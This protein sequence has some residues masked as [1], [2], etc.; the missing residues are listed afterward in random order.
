MK[1]EEILNRMSLF[2]LSFNQTPREGD[3]FEE[4]IQK[5]NLLEQEK[6]GMSPKQHSYYY[7]LMYKNH[8]APLTD[9]CKLKIEAKIRETPT[10]VLEESDDLVVFQCGTSKYRAEQFI[11]CG[12]GHV[13]AECCIGREDYTLPEKVLGLQVSIPKGIRGE[14]ERTTYYAYNKAA[15][16]LVEPAILVG[17]IA[18][19]YLFCERNSGEYCISI[20]DYDKIIDPE[21]LTPQEYEVRYL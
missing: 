9:S 14:V 18:K 12:D 6:N 11:A 21:I 4:I 2:Y 19:K 13:W 17:K 20:R 5:Y 3:T 8:W 7:Y 10:S 15:H 1:K 16:Y